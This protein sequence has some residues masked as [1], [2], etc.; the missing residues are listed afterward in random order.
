MLLRKACWLGVSWEPSEAA[1]LCKL[2]RD[3]DF[4]KVG[5]PFVRAI[6]YERLFALLCAADA[7]MVVFFQKDTLR[8]WSQ[9]FP[10]R[11]SPSSVIGLYLVSLK[12]TI[13]TL[14]GLISGPPVLSGLR[15]QRVMATSFGGWSLGGFPK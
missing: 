4:C 6:W 5:Q 9:Q 8:L 14:A 1:A 12:C 10:F 15:I 13:P 11:H 7:Y 2:T 3:E